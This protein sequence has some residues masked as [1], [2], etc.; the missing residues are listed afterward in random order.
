LPGW[1]QFL[2]AQGCASDL[3]AGLGESF[4]MRISLLKRG[5]AFVMGQ[6]WVGSGKKQANL[7]LD[8]EAAASLRH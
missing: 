6:L 5:R 7:L 2:T 1:A 8:F 3:A 4:L